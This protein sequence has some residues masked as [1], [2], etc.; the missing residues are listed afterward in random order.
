MPLTPLDNSYAGAPD[1][2][3]GA[4]NLMNYASW[5]YRRCNEILAEPDL[6]MFKIYDLANNCQNFRSEMDKWLNGGGTV[7][8]VHDWLVRLTNASGQ[9]NVV[10]TYDEINNDY[11]TLYFTAETFLTWASANMTKQGDIIAGA[12]GD[13]WGVSW[14]D[15]W[16]GASVV[17]QN[18]APLIGRILIYPLLDGEITLGPALSDTRVYVYPAII[19]DVGGT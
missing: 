7:Q 15:A 4:R 2:E 16:G 1:P 5:I 14:G 12:W 18:I 11:K 17:V 3:R 19:G 10:K 13:S 6:D 9:G 8:K